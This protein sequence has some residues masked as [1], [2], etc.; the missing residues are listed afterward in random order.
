MP[1]LLKLKT[2][3]LCYITPKT[4]YVVIVYKDRIAKIDIDA[5]KTTTYRRKLANSLFDTEINHICTL[6][7]DI[8][9]TLQTNKK[10]YELD[11]SKLIC[12]KSRNTQG[13]KVLN[14]N[15]FIKVR[16]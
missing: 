2:L 5:Y 13:V 11:T 8:K 16:L 4:K 1:G 10:D 7:N 6:E 12:K 14:N 3:N 9:I 15:T